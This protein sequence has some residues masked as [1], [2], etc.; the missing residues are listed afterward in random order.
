LEPAATASEIIVT[1]EAVV[2]ET[3]A[4][5]LETAVPDRLWMPYSSGSYGN[6]ILT[7]QA[8][9]IVYIE[10]PAAIE[11]FFDYENGR[12]AYGAEFWYA[13]DNGIDAVTDLWVYDFA[14]GTE[15][16]WLDG[17]VGRADWSLDGEVLA[18]ALHNGVVFDL[19][20]VDGPNS[21]TKIVED[22]DPFYSW[23]PL[24]TDIA[25]VRDG[26]LTLTNLDGEETPLVGGLYQ[27]SSWVGDT[28]LWLLDYGLIAYADFPVTFAS[29]DSQDLYEPISA[30][31][32]ALDVNKRPFQMLWSKTHR[33][34]IMQYEAMFGPAVQ[35]FQFDEDIYTVTQIIELGDDMAIVDWYE[36]DESVIILQSG[37]PKVYSLS[38][39]KFIEP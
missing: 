35:I 37:E 38:T 17:N 2:E 3:E 31:G 39:H 4:A 6:P 32:D 13:A 12:I 21:V 16:L 28:P 36:P 11:A 15:E 24:G 5:G 33:Q 34:M 20:L 22:I 23:S 9:E 10:E 7:L 27:E 14:T 29:L 8:G 26:V 1:Q 30:S 25:F 18:V 19:V